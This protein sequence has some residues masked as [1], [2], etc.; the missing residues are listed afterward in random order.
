MEKGQ[1]RDTFRLQESDQTADSGRGWLRFLEGNWHMVLEDFFMMLV[2]PAVWCTETFTSI[3][4]M[5]QKHSVTVM[6]YKF[7]GLKREILK[8]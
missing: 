6:L 5:L 8:K 1:Y 7:V 2:D 3:L 4:T